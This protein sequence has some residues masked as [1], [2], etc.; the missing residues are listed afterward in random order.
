MSNCESQRPRSVPSVGL[1]P[2]PPSLQGRV[3]CVSMR[4]S[5]VAFSRRPSAG[6]STKGWC[7]IRLYGCFLETP[8]C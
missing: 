8:A 1:T 5:V 6:R 7:K 4:L 3:E 2:R